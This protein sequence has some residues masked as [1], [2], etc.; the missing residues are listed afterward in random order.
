MLSTSVKSRTTKRES[1]P[2]LDKTVTFVVTLSSGGQLI[3]TDIESIRR[4]AAIYMDLLG[5]LET[6]LDPPTVPFCVSNG[7]DNTAIRSLE[8]LWKFIDSAEEPFIRLCTWTTNTL[9]VVPSRTIGRTLQQDYSNHAI[10]KLEHMVDKLDNQEQSRLSNQSRF[11]LIRENHRHSAGFVKELE[12]HFVSL[13]Q[14]TTSLWQQLS[15]RKTMCEAAMQ[16]ITQID[17]LRDFAADLSDAQ[18]NHA[19]QYFE[20]INSNNPLANFAAEHLIKLLMPDDAEWEEVS[21]RKNIFDEIRKD[22]SQQS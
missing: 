5:T 12:E 19:Q 6:F 14:T 8:E 16:D 7:Q 15:E 4:S 2:D 13:D 20:L 10:L 21:S 11:T 3:R 17:K 1:R 22:T 9:V 18:R